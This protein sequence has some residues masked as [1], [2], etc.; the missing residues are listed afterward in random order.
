MGC[1]GWHGCRICVPISATVLLFCLQRDWP[2]GTFHIRQRLNYVA[3]D[4]F[5]CRCTILH[6][7]TCIS[8]PD[9]PCNTILLCNVGIAVLQPFRNA[10]T[11][12]FN[13]FKWALISHGM[14]KPIW[15]LVLKIQILIAEI[16]LRQHYF[17]IFRHVISSAY[18][19]KWCTWF[20]RLTFFHRS[21]LIYLQTAKRLVTF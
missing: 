20:R 4:S 6:I 3:V 21:Y 15:P 14:A 18:C 5:C 1:G 8:F 2:V 13:R 7:A 9:S 17:C 16:S 19:L 12:K 11:A 10:S